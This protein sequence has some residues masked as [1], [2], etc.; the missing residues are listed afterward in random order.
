MKQHKKLG[1]KSVVLI[2]SSIIILV[3]AT[4][5]A[6]LYWNN[7]R[8]F[9]T[10]S[11]QK[12]TFSFDVS[13]SPGWWSP[14]NYSST[15]EDA[16]NY[17]GSEGLPISSL[18]AFNGKKGDTNDQC[19]VMASY[20][21]GTVNI[22]AALKKKNMPLGSS[23]SYTFIGTTQH[24]MQTPEGTKEYTMYQYDLVSSTPS[25]RG[26]EFGFFQ[27]KD[28]Y[29]RMTGICPTPDTLVANETALSAISLK[30]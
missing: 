14:G 30:L 17:K 22:Q 5:A 7:T 24:T 6:L 26:N 25:Q 9:H 28:G 20:E 11:E 4:T 15:A 12:P 29:V 18:N 16:K 23:D 3:A 13:K 2:G 1:T 27:L 8:T 10:S 21:A 19:F